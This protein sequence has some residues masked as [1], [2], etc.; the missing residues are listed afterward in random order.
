MRRRER[1]RR[2]GPIRVA[3]L[4][5]DLDA[6][7]A[8]RQMLILAATLPSASFEVRFLLLSDRGVLAAEAEAVGARVHVLGLDRAQCTGIGLRCLP[9][10]L[11]VI[12]RYRALTADVDIVDAWLIP[13][14]IFAVFAQPFATGPI[15]LGGRRSLND[16]YAS[17]S[18]L[19]RLLATI[20]ARRMTAIVANSRI[21]AMEA[22]Q[23]DGIAADRVRVI[24]N[25][26]M[27][28]MGDGGRRAPT[29]A[30]WGFDPAHIVV[31]CVGNYKP[32]KG[33]LSL[34]TV[35]DQLRLERPDL[36]YVLVGEGPL[37]S[38]LERGIRRLALGDIVVLHGREAN[39]R[40]LYGAFDI[41][42]Q[43]SDSEGLPNVIL[44][45]AASGLPI[46]ATS[47]G[48]TPEILSSNVDAILV[49]SGDV[50]G[51][52]SAISE[53]AVDPGLRDR[54]GR[55]ALARSADYAPARLAE[56]DRGALSRTGWPV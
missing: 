13:S 35:A 12:R 38:D 16:V 15:L 4:T 18:R 11:R 42:V 14:M 9:G 2:T 19:R 50:Q 45:A 3:Y 44:E 6:G 55:A 51:I 37:R 5:P 49:P 43:A 27:P 47:V 30:G 36:R 48:G 39:A 46:V 28:A 17:K 34:L 40:S 41:F 20:A 21:A 22:H 29:R 32:G 53:L 23:V 10:L 26:V 8:E 31:G 24:P 56:I 54:L 7:G 33:L 1:T 52:A 25:A